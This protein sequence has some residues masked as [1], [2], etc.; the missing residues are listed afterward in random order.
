MERIASHKT[1][2][3]VARAALILFAPLLLA[4]CTSVFDD[5]YESY[6]GNY[7]SVTVKK[8]HQVVVE[9]KESTANV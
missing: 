3:R 9:K 5:D 6:S 7:H 1:G 8:G 2:T 4:N